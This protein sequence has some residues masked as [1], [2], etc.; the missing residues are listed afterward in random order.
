M[1][2]HFNSVFLHDI[3]LYKIPPLTIF[4]HFST[5][6]DVPN[7]PDLLELIIVT[8][9]TTIIRNSHPPLYSQ[10]CEHLKTAPSISNLNDQLFARVLK[11]SKSEVRERLDLDCPSQRVKRVAKQLYEEGFIIEAGSVVIHMQDF[12]SGV[13]TMNDAIGYIGRLFSK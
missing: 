2:C 7:D 5:Q 4:N 13:Q 1:V 12:H 6:L 9:N 11:C 3:V 8:D 10:I